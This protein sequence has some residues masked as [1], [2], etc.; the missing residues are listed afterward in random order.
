MAYAESIVGPAIVTP[1]PTAKEAEKGYVAKFLDAAIGVAMGPAQLWQDT[2]AT[3]QDIMNP[4]ALASERPYVKVGYNSGQ[5]AASQ[6]SSLFTAMGTGAMIGSTLGPIGAAVGGTVGAFYGTFVSNPADGN[7]VDTAKALG[8]PVFDAMNKYSHSPTDTAM[9]GR[10]KNLAVDG[11]F[12]AGLGVGAAGIRMMKSRRLIEA[13][14]KAIASIKND[15]NIAKQ[16]L[17]GGKAKAFEQEA[18]KAA[19]A[20][21]GI[22]A[23][24]KPTPVDPQVTKAAVTPEE[25]PPAVVA[26]Q[27]EEANFEQFAKESMETRRADLTEIN[28]RQAT[29]EEVLE[30]YEV[31]ADVALAGVQPEPEAPTPK[32][33]DELTVETTPEKVLADVD[34]HI[35]EVLPEAGTGT[36]N[37]GEDMRAGTENASWNLY[38]MMRQLFSPG[39]REFEPIYK[40]G[41]EIASNPE[42]LTAVVQ[43]AARGESLTVEESAA[44]L[45]HSYDNTVSPESAELM[46]K[47]MTGE[48][49]D[50]EVAAFY[51]GFNDI[52]SAQV[53]PLMLDAAE[54]NANSL[55]LGI[56]RY[57]KD[58]HAAGVMPDGTPMP[59]NPIPTMRAKLAAV[60]AYVE[61][62]GGNA[63]AAE[64]A[65]EFIKWLTE[66]ATTGKVPS[67]VPAPLKPILPRDLP[68]LIEHAKAVMAAMDQ[69]T[70]MNLMPKAAARSWGGRLADGIVSYRIKNMLNHW[71]TPVSSALGGIA[72]AGM[73][74]SVN[75]LK[76]PYVGSVDLFN[77]IMRRDS[78][79]LFMSTLARANSYAE[80]L[81]KGFKSAHKLAYDGWK[82]YD[83]SA[84]TVNYALDPMEKIA[85][86]QVTADETFDAANAN[87][88]AFSFIKNG[89][90]SIVSLGERMLFSWDR[91]ISTI[92]KEA[93]YASE[94]AFEGYERGLRG[95]DLEAF[96]KDPPAEIIAK[97]KDEA[98]RDANRF[99]YRGTP[100][101]PLFKA[102]VDGHTDKDMLSGAVRFMNPF[103]RP[104]L[105]SME[106][107]AEHMPGANLLLPRTREALASGDPNRIA[108]VMAR[109]T[110][111]TLPIMGAMQAA[112]SGYI[113]GPSK[114][115]TVF[116]DNGKRVPP[117]HV[118][119]GS[120]WVPIEKVFGQGMVSSFLKIGASLDTMF[121]YME[122]GQY[123]AAMSLALFG[124]GESA[125]FSRFSVL[126]D[127]DTDLTLAASGKMSMSQLADKYALKNYPKTFLPGYRIAQDVMGDDSERQRVVTGEGFEFIA[128]AL[129]QTYRE[130]YT[131]EKL[132][133][134]PNYL[135]E[136]AQ[137][138]S[139]FFYTF[140]T[141][142][143][144]MEG[145]VSTVPLKVLRDIDA[146]AKVYEH[147]GFEQ[148]SRPVWP[149]VITD[150]TTG[151]DI[152]L[153]PSLV[154]TF[155]ELV[156]GYRTVGDQ[157][158]KM[159]NR[160]APRG[161][162]MD[163]REAL[164]ALYTKYSGVIAKFYNNEELTSDEINPLIKEI[165]AQKEYQHN[166][167]KQLIMQDPRFRS[168]VNEAQQGQAQLNSIIN[169]GGAQ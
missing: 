132:A 169:Y 70:L 100:E 138:R 74:V 73:R 128:N 164:E 11:W 18:A 160:L 96:I 25:A 141:Y 147:L 89:V 137:R 16:S 4:N 133:T 124:M 21:P 159:S 97:Y 10:M 106:L 151:I 83:P 142:S 58:Y 2:K 112:R 81:Y 40:A 50:A 35:D 41:K 19:K 53:A 158:I 57:I 125:D 31:E 144:G 27:V 45:I 32:V 87:G 72:D 61:A 98:T 88:G 63:I 86:K 123:N 64:D 43:K 157:T 12:E 108:E 38:S 102:M 121:D 153:T 20:N 107:I 26:A 115:G 24:A 116:D 68:S 3:V 6:V 136:V 92:T 104:A 113:S 135:G 126:G 114:D 39:Q 66:A 71:W 69:E 48:A 99:A 77:K 161:E 90:W 149:K 7:M 146:H 85:A 84:T 117:F 37:A 30:S 33:Y 105:I 165:N 111:G 54:A 49:T 168:L 55:R 47:V 9:E 162:Q 130:T 67:T 95:K 14:K 152:Q 76:L 36:K 42:Q 52:V 166:Q 80:H 1:E 101:I 22:P 91:A 122:E 60:N 129:T 127:L 131:P 120:K 134:R 65:A 5:Q 78:P 59:Q 154:N 94:A 110:A 29:N 93:R 44:V 156:S 56:R 155:Q 28:G 163:Y 23:A 145:G 17:P 15:Y 143:S 139:T 119:V 109:A 34:K 140:D 167:A 118:K 51:E 62:R 103:L 79:D 46:A 148:V 75:Y 150:S 13:G 82:M 8:I